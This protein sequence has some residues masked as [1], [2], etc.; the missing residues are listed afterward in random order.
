MKLLPVVRFINFISPQENNYRKKHCKHG[1]DLNIITNQR[2]DNL[3]RRRGC[4]ECVRVRD[5]KRYS[6]TRGG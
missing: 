4:L 2:Y 5:R 3:G 1:H 6:A